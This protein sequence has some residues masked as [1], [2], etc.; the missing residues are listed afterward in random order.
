MKTTTLVATIVAASALVFIP[1]VFAK[2]D[3][4]SASEISTDTQK[5]SMDL[6]FDEPWGD[7]PV[8][9]PAPEAARAALAGLDARAAACRSHRPFGHPPIN[10]NSPELIPPHSTGTLTADSTAPQA[11]TVPERATVRSHST[12]IERR[13]FTPLPLEVEYKKFPLRLMNK[14]FKLILD[15]AGE[16]G[17]AMPATAAA[18][19][20][21][22]TRRPGC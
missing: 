1:P 9:T 20:I 3:G 18:L 8:L 6:S 17:A 19:Q 5:S 11:D 13:F 22:A 15:K 21:N 16:L 10:P 12:R 14:D 2:A 7:G 4:G